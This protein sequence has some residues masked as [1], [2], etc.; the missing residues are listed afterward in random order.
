MKKINEIA[1]GDKVWFPH[2]SGVRSGTIVAVKERST[3]RGK[4]VC[5]DTGNEW[6]TVEVEPEKIFLTYRDAQWARANKLQLEASS[7]LQEAANAF[8][9]AGAPPVS[10][11]PPET[12]AGRE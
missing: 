1:V 8:R 11:S 3:F 5:V 9:D 2:F 6:T 10:E 7:K 4:K 12:D